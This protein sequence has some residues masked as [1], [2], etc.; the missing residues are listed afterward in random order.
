MAK[1]HENGYAFTDENGI[2]HMVF[3]PNEACA[4]LHRLLEKVGH[5]GNLRTSEQSDDAG[6]VADPPAHH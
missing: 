1:D 5:G 3:G 2:Q 4:A 6:R